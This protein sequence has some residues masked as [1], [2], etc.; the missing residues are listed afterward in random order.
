M[1]IFHV[2]AQKGASP[3]KWRGLTWLL[4][5]EVGG[6]LAALGWEVGKDVVCSVIRR[7]PRA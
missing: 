1:S 3:I 7:L 5:R 6:G 4:V 2:M